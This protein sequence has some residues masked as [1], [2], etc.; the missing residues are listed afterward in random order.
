MERILIY[1]G[2]GILL[3]FGASMAATPIDMFAWMSLPMPDDAVHRIELRAFY[4]GLEM[5]LGALLLFWARSPEYTRAALWLVA[6]SYGSV[7]VVRLAA[8]AIEGGAPTGLIV[9]LLIELGIAITAVV[10]VRR[11]AA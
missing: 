7:G 6:G 3:A 9:A 4:G 1:L 2:A 8:I 5:G 11:T 10:L